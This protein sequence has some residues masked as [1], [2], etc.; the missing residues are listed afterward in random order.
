VITNRPFR[1]AED[2]ISKSFELACKA[3]MPRG[4]QG[5]LV[6]FSRALATGMRPYEAAMAAGYPDGPSAKSNAR[7]RACRPDV[8]CIVAE[9]RKPAAE[10][11]NIT[12]EELIR[13][14]DQIFE[15]AIPAGQ[16]GAAVNA[17]KELGI[18]S[19]KRI[20][21]AERGEPGEF[22]RMSDDE[23]RQAVADRA[24]QLGFVRK[25]ETQ[26]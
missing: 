23:L 15:L 8:R 1:L 7:K 6:R 18:L 3:S 2:L 11:L 24:E 10:R 16:L 13:R 17:L 12:Q 21:R 19:G 22:D 25:K 26:H 9:I 14:A 5:R 4:S 20:E